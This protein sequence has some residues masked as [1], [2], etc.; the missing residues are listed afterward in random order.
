MND[1][2]VFIINNIKESQENQ[3]LLVKDFDIISYKIYS[4]HYIN[5]SFC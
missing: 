1:P 3:E 4:C 2:I 5:A